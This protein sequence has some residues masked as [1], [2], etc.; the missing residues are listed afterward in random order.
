MTSET[1]SVE[2]TRAGRPSS[3]GKKSVS[4]AHQAY[5]V[6]PSNCRAWGIVPRAKPQSLGLPVELWEARDH[7]LGD[8]FDTHGSRPCV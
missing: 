3:S 4:H 2:V 5:K 1:G 8:L 6:R 7:L